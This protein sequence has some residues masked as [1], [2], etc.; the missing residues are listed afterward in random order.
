MELKEQIKKAADEIKEEL[1]ELSRRIHEN[2]E[3]GFQEYEA[4]KNITD[5]M[6]KH[7][8]RIEKNIAGL[9]TAFRAE[10]NCK[11]SGPTIAFLAEYDAL[12]EIGHGC[13]HNLIAAMSAGAAIS[14]SKIADRINGR[15][16]VLGTPAEEGG[17]GK[18]IMVNKG[19]FDDIDYALMIHPSTENLIC[20]GGLATRGMKIEYFGKST[21][22]AAPESG[23]NALQA[24]IQTFNGIDSI[25]ALLPL[26]SNING[27]I[28]EGGKASNIIPDYAAC[29][30]TV[31]AD[32]LKDLKIVIGY[33]E[34]VVKSVEKL[35]GAKAEITKS[36][37][38]TERYPNRCIDERLKENVAEF[39]EVM[40]YPDPNMKYGSSD[41]GNVSL[42]VPAI[43]AYLKIA[44]PEVNSHSVD[45]TIA[46]ITDIAHQQMLNGAKAMAMTGLDILA[47]NELRDNI[48][49]EFEEKVP[50]YSRE[51]LE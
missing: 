37:L 32:T 42:V 14:L 43:H 41:I 15:I 8:F 3:L 2:P 39:G 6:H 29:K 9:E 12:P 7:G 22:S 23:I 51:D 35:T 31:R 44:E 1:I 40:G 21:H 47:D 25:R 11:G 17:G 20:R 28:T 45:F 49:M 46:S 5:L 30:F 4:V 16:V 19:C 38:Y 18:V 27:I 33:M 48:R 26:K 10:Y 36:I 13:G 24:V 50:K 34:R